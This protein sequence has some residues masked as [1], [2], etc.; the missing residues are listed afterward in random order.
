MEDFVKNEFKWAPH[1]AID[2]RNEDDVSTIGGGWSGPKKN[3]VPFGTLNLKS[4]FLPNFSTQGPGE[5]ED[6]VSMN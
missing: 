2:E 6:R 3:P 1:A 5:E 4:D